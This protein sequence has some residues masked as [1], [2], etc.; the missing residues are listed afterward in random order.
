MPLVLNG[1][2]GVQD[3]SGAFVAGTAVASTSGTSITFTSIPSWVK[4]VTIMFQGV[5]TNGSA[6]PLVRIGSGSVATSGYLSST[7]SLGNTVGTNNYTNGF[8]L[9]NTGQWGAS[10]IF[11]GTVVLTLINL[12]TNS[13]VASG[14]LARSDGTNTAVLA[15][16]IALAGALTVVSATTSNGTDAFDA[17]T[18]NILYE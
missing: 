5:S 3:N 17:G 11:H 9:Y 12:S 14:T 6:D 15:G 4:R 13:W 7:S 18:I 10:V 2:T 16:S 8:G 1:T